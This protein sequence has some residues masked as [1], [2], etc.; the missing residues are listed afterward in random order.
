MGQIYS[1]AELAIAVDG[2]P[3]CDSGFLQQRDIDT[4]W[5]KFFPRCSKDQQLLKC[6]IRDNRKS[7]Q[8]D[9]WPSVAV[10]PLSKRGWAL[11]ESILPNR[12]LHF[13]G[14][15]M[16][17]ECNCL[18]L[19]ELGDAEYSQVKLLGRA[20][21]VATQEA[22][23]PKF[24]SADVARRQREI[25]TEYEEIDEYHCTHFT[26]FANQGSRDSVF[27]AWQLIVEHYSER[28]LSKQTDKLAAISGLASCVVDRLGLGI[29][30]YVA[31]LWKDN[32]ARGLLWYVRGSGG[33]FRPP[34]YRAPSWSWASV[35]G[36]VEYF[37]EHYQFS[38]QQYITICNVHCTVSPLDPTG[39][40]MAASLELYGKLTP[41]TLRIERTMPN[42]YKSEYTGMAGCA[43][44]SHPHHFVWVQAQ[45]SPEYEVLPDELLNEGRT[46]NY[47]CFRIGHTVDNSTTGA[48]M[49]WLLLRKEHETTSVYRRVGIGYYHYRLWPS[50]RMVLP[51]RKIRLFDHASE[52]TITLV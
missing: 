11:Q 33:V 2:S 19:R 26:D 31:G 21:R 42:G 12:T 47:C 41:V 51:M 17:W 32:L 10:C 36:G 20:L 23:K 25:Q 22:L 38:F 14:R 37:K 52:N 40:V 28:E 13:A 1:N 27:W 4:I 16:V 43:S 9:P 49:W 39:R 30:S 24:S 44:H 8:P 45:D 5:R 34:V 48:R 50:E 29:D 15:E 7:N 6:W 3:S 18:C 35:N 46:S